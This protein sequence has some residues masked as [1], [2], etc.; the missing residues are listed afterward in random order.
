MPSRNSFFKNK[1]YSSALRYLKEN[2]SDIL[3]FFKQLA[4]QIRKDPDKYV[5][6]IE[7]NK[8][9]VF[10]PQQ[11]DK[12]KWLQDMKIKTVLDVG[13]W[14]GDSVRLFHDLFPG[15]RIYS[16]EPLPDCFAKLQELEKSVPDF[17]A[18]NFA[19]GDKSG[20]IQI[21][22]SS[23]SPS[24]SLLKMES[25]HK[26]VFPFTAGETVEE[27]EI[28]TLDSV[29]GELDLTPD[30]LM[31]IDVQGFEE[32]VIKGAEQTLKKVKILI[33]ELSFVQLYAGGP[34]FDR[35]YTLLKEHGFTYSGS[36]HQLL[37][38]KDGTILQQNGVFIRESR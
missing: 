26:E 20:K 19:I 30:V 14:Q 37:S 24:S 21:N 12:Y 6:L 28:R 22:R 27:V 32:N 16:F 15:A 17:K 5:R 7:E 2:D 25:A 4:P 31:K 3:Y 38:P 11:K 18:F 8:E 9:N 35:I 1:I 29:T 23:F 34:M 36:W 13:A 33:V 10:A